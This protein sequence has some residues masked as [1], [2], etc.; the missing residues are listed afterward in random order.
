MKSLPLLLFALFFMASCSKYQKYEGVPFEEKNPHDWE[1]PAVSQINREVQH[2]YFIPF[3]SVDQARANDKWASPY[4]QSLNGKWQFHLSHNPYERPAW[5]FKNDYDTRDWDS[6]PVPA[7]WE[8]QGY[9][10]PIYV[11]ITYPHAKTPPT[12]QKNYNP[13][14]SYKRTFTIPADWN[15]KEVFLHFGAVSSAMYVWVNEQMV[16]YSEDSKT[17][18]E[19]N[20]TK[21]LVEGENSLAVEVYRWCDGSYMEDQDFWRMSGITRDV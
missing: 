18:A 11:N 12:I 19:F 4:I 13:V 6:I 7:N 16:G 20:I 5:F 9:D 1:N 15:E 21:Y 10:Y 17:P 2:A 14:G 3:A 8:L